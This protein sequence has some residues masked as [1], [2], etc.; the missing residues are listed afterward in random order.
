MKRTISVLL[1]AGL[2]AAVSS[3]QGAGASGCG[4]EDN[5][6]SDFSNDN[7]KKDD[8]RSADVGK[9]HKSGIS[10]KLG[11][12]KSTNNYERDFDQGDK[13]WGEGENFE[14]KKLD[15]EVNTSCGEKQKDQKKESESHKKQNLEREATSVNAAEDNSQDNNSDQIFDSQAAEADIKSNFRRDQNRNNSDVRSTTDVDTSKLHDQESKNIDQNC[16]AN[17]NRAHHNEDRKHFDLAKEK[18]D[19]HDVQFAEQRH[20][21]AGIKQGLLSDECIELKEHVCAEKDCCKGEKVDK[22]RW[23]KR[24]CHKKSFREKKG[25][26][27]HAKMIKNKGKFCDK[28]GV[29]K[30]NGGSKKQIECAVQEHNKK[31]CDNRAHS[32]DKTDDETKSLTQ[33]ADSTDNSRFDDARTQQDQRKQAQKQVK[34]AK[35]DTKKV[36]E[37]TDY[38]SNLKVDDS[39]SKD[40]QT[41]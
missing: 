35:R 41:N 12:F 25:Q 7:S 21:D 23:L 36:R 27:K 19:N 9:Y 29:L 11:G 31:I 8:F 40:S 2:I 37:D 5:F 1:G 33:H 16:A 22:K 13:T 39:N 6:S 14:S 26:H 24:K 15:E 34:V 18:H 4:C 20:Q 17:A 38:E 28:F 10:N 3:T 32:L 30:K